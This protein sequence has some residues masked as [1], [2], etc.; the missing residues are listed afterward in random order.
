MDWQAVAR[1]ASPVTPAKAGVQKSGKRLDSRLRGNDECSGPHT[2]STSCWRTEHRSQPDN[3][4]AATQAGCPIVR[5]DRSPDE[6]LE[7]LPG[8]RAAA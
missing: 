2:F 8:L 5:A 6:A 1:L 4:T 7:F 3:S